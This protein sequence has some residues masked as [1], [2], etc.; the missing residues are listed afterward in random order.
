MLKKA[1]SLP[2][3]SASFGGVQIYRTSQ[4]RNKVYTEKY[5]Y[6]YYSLPLL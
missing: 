1:K 4:E 6:V 5:Y 3:S 2:S